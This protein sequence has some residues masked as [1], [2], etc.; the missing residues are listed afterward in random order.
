MD[1]SKTN[2]NSL[3]KPEPCG[4][5]EP[6]TRVRRHSKPRR[7]RVS[8]ISADEQ[9]RPGVGTLTRTRNLVLAA[10]RVWELKRG[11]HS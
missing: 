7:L 10:L 11:I 2:L 3:T 1:S 8:A 9:R 5:S 4:N 6:R